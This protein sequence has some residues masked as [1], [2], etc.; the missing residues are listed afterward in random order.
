MNNDEA[1][2]K[3]VSRRT[4]RRCT[5]LS[6]T[7]AIPCLILCVAAYFKS[8]WLKPGAAL[9]PDTVNHMRI[10]IKTAIFIVIPALSILIILSSYLIW[11]L[12]N[13]LDDDKSPE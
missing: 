7:A 6:L 1:S 12:S 2:Q 9:N 8:D 5:M 10:L 11:K 4:A 13:K 3:Q